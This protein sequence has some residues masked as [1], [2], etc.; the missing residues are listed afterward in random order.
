MSA[1]VFAFLSSIVI[2]TVKSVF[3]V[4]RFSLEAY[5]GGDISRRSKLR[6]SLCVAASL[7]V[8]RLA[9]LAALSDLQR[10]RGRGERGLGGVTLS[11]T[12]VEAKNDRLGRGLDCRGAAQLLTPT[13]T[14]SLTLLGNAEV[15]SLLRAA[16][17]AS[18]LPAAKRPRSFAAEFRHSQR[19]FP[20]VA[21]PRRHRR[22]R[23]SCPRSLPRSSQGPLRNSMRVLSVDL[24]S[25]VARSMARTTLVTI[26]VVPL[27]RLWSSQDRPERIDRSRPRPPACE[28]LRLAR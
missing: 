16:P 21:A 6:R 28:N 23:R 11:G 3:S 9:K 4:G 2:G 1:F 27:G 7:G 18:A 22:A 13:S 17:D 5:L 19:R 15:E 20:K 26:P 12:V 24:I 8:E 10:G 14:S 25:R